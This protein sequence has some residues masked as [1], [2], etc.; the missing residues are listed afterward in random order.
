LLIMAFACLLMWGGSAMALST[1]HD[2]IPTLGISESF[3]YLPSIIAGVLII[4]FS[5]EHLLM[6]FVAKPSGSPWN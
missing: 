4:S 1:M 2:T 3:R 5:I 6:L